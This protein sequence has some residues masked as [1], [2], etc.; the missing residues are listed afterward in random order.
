MVYAEAMISIVIPTLNAERELPATLAAL[1]PGAVA[2]LITEVIVADGG[3]KDATKAIACDA[4][5]QWVQGSPGRGQQLSAGAKQARS[6]WFLFLHAD[7]VLADDWI[8]DIGRFLAEV[9]RSQQDRAAVFRFALASGKRRARMLEFMVALRTSVFGLPYGDQGLLISRRFYDAVGGFQSME[10]MEDVAIIRQ[11]G[12]RR[13]DVLPSRA[14]SSAARF[15]QDGFLRRSL[16]N[17]HCLLLYFLGMRIDKIKRK[18][19]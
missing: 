10:I 19:G 8:E 9:E 4:G 18:Y 13:I 2:G 3:S 1:V 12:K 6:P 14:V 5:C 7:T 17:L 16:R 15:E 11:I